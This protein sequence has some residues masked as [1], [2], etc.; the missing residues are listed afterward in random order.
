MFVK[1]IQKRYLYFCSFLL[2]LIIHKEMGVGC[3]M[4][5]KK[6]RETYPVEMFFWSIALPGFG[7]ILNKH[8]LKGIIFIL[9]EFLIN[10]LGRINE[11]IVYSFQGEIHR[12]IAAVDYEWIMFYPCLYVFAIW[13]AYKGGKERAN[14][15]NT[16]FE[17]IPF[18]IAAYIT[19]IGVIYSNLPIFGI[20]FGPIFTPIIA[21][22]IGFM[23]GNLVK[24]W[25]VHSFYRNED[26]GAK[27]SK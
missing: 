20:T 25:L 3:T 13:D 4:N 7:Q 6:I 21:I 17:S 16:P 10:V 23:I 24:K 26:N 2:I 15:K 11:A 1:V 12:A 27:E 8:Y 14:I 9:M 22:F 18:S 5:D 19:T